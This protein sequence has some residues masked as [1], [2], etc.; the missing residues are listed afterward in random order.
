[1]VDAEGNAVSNTYTL[2]SGYG[3]GVVV[4]GFLLNN[5]MGD[6][7][8][9]PGAT[10][11]GWGI[12]TPANVIAPEK[13][14]LSSMSPT[15]V[16]RD[17]ELRLVTGSPGGRTIP[18]TTLDVVLGVTLFNEDIRTAV[19]APRLHHQWMPDSFEM[20]AGAASAEALELLRGMGHAVRERRARSQGDA[21]SILYDAKTRTA[22]AANDKRSSDSGARAPQA[23]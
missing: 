10:N 1:V 15:I 22:T 11:T 7:N 17:G 8:K 14:M 18:N 16:T 4:A 21:H 3:S 6:F 20:E 2:E 9:K 19:D 12:G 23:P 5:E 13:R